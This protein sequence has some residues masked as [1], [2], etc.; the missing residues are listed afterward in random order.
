MK[1]H[2]GCGAAELDVLPVGEGGV[3]GAGDEGIGTEVCRDEQ[4]GAERMRVKMGLEVGNIDTKS[5]ELVGGKEGGGEETLEV[6]GHVL[7]GHGWCW[8]GKV[9]KMGL[10]GVSGADPPLD[11]FLGVWTPPSGRKCG[12]WVRCGSWV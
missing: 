2:V 8:G 6:G 4:V 7:G 3:K 10:N 5:V 12:S 11:G 1:D 9:E